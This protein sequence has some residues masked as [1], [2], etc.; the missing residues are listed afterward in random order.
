MFYPVNRY[1]HILCVTPIDVVYL[2]KD[3]V[4]VD[5]DENLPP[6]KFGRRK[7]GAHSVLELPTGTVS[8]TNIQIGH[9]LEIENKN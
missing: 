6:G 4:V 3:L 1:T 7:K 9:Y 5:I 2:T 8:R